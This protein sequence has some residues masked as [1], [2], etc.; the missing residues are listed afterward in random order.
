MSDDPLF[1]EKSVEPVSK[2]GKHKKVMSE[3]RRAAL[4]LQLIKARAASLAK[5][6]QKAKDKKLKNTK[7]QEYV[8]GF[9]KISRIWSPNKRSI[10]C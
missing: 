1:E 10:H 4:K 7:I 8:Q 3:E 6:Q 5:R 2:K 9:F